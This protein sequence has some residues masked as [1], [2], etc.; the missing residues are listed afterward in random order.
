MLAHHV[1]CAFL[2]LGGQQQVGSVSNP[3]R[4]R[5]RDVLHGTVVLTSTVKWLVAGRLV[6]GRAGRGPRNNWCGRNCGCL[7][8]RELA[9][10]RASRAKRAGMAM[11]HGRGI[12]RG[13]G[14][15]NWP[16]IIGQGC[17]EDVRQMRRRKYCRKM[18]WIRFVRVFTPWVLPHL[19][20]PPPA[21]RAGFPGGATPRPPGAIWTLLTLSSRPRTAC[22]PE[23]TT[24][25]PSVA[26]LTPPAVRDK[27]QNHSPRYCETL[28][29]A[30][31]VVHSPLQGRAGSWC[32]AFAI[33]FA[34]SSLPPSYAWPRPHPA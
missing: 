33:A 5:A 3:A 7:R 26:S 11:G 32:T 10:G 1:M 19:D 21:P 4:G 15:V 13:C 12:G 8:V 24:T 31:A 16:R 6:L 18:S 22:S 17:L 27:L 9:R 28:S 25:H 34:L 14:A 20:P 30:E 23:T 2:G 29:G